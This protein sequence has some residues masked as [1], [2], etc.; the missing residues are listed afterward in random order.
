M[1]FGGGG[2][3]APAFSSAAGRPVSI[4]P[5]AALERGHS[6][7]ME[8]KRHREANGVRRVPENPL[9][10]AADV[11]PSRPEYAVLGA[12][13]P[14]VARYHDETILLLRVAE[15]PAEREAGWLVS[16]IWNAEQGEIEVLRFRADDPDISDVEPRTFRHRG[17]LYLTSISHLRLARSTDGVHFVVEEEPS[18]F[19]SEPTEALGI[20][21]CRITQIEHTYWITYKCVSRDG[22]CISLASTRD[23]KAYE[24]H[25]IAFEPH[26]LDIVIFPDKVGGDYV[27]L[28]RPETWIAG[29]PAMWLARSPD[30]LHWGRH[31]PLMKP[32]PGMW[33]SGRIGASAVPFLTDRGWLEIYHGAD[34]TYTY[35]AGLVLLDRE[36][37]CKVIG[38]SERPIL[39]PETKY[40]TS[41]FF[42]GVVF[43]S[44]ACVVDR[45]VTLYYGAS[46]DVTAA[47]VATVDE[48]LA[49]LPNF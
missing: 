44:G 3:A 27:A 15:V 45:Q 14:G 31:V 24:K 10:T 43:A 6:T 2:D 40:E 18:V 49:G 46:D 32:R 17:L 36:N 20:E 1:Q 5:R 34:L 22:I 16:P 30:L 11:K 25:G 9:I 8:K 41:G 42:G 19:P 12:F 48:L 7:R 23:F 29:A 35:C 21:D 4:Q 37:P 28:T 39:R 13:N 38:R 26:N 47:A 33:D